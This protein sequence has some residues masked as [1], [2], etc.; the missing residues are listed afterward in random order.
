MFG[1]FKR[2]PAGAKDGER[3]GKEPAAQP[4]AAGPAELIARG[5]RLLDAGRAGEAAECYRQAAALAPDDPAPHVNLGF[6]LMDLGRPAEARQSLERAL[7]LSPANADAH[8]MLG[9]LERA[10]GNIDAAIDH[11][12]QVITAQPDLE[13][14]HGELCQT[15]LQA[16]QAV[17]AREVAEQGLARFPA[18]AGLLTCLGNLAL[19][20][21]KHAEAAERFRQALAADPQAAAAH[22]NLALALRQLGRPEEAVDALKQALA[23]APEFVEAYVELGRLCTDLGR[24]PDALASFQRALAYRP[25]SPATHMELGLVQQKL[26]RLDAAADGL[27][28]ALSLQPDYVEAHINLGNILKDQGRLEEAVRCYGRALALKPD[29]Y[30]AH[31]NLGTIRMWQGEMAAAVDSLRRALALRPDGIEAHNNLLFSMNFL[32]DCTPEAYLAEAR[33]FGAALTARARPY[34][35]W[36]CEGDPPEQRPLRVGLVSGDFRNHPVGYFLETILANVDPARLELTAYATQPAEDALTA[37]I[38]PRFARWRSLAGLDDE[39]AAALIHEDGIHLLVDLSGHTA[40]HRLPVFAWRP[41]PVQLSWL[42]YFAT[43]GVAEIDYLLADPVAI[44]EAHRG[45]FSEEVCYLPDTRLCFTPP[46]VAPPVAPLPAAR[47]GFVT[48]GCFQNLP[49]ITDAVLSAWGAILRRMPDA[50]LRLQ[51]YQLSI[52]AERERLR[53]R[54]TGA[55]IAP[56]RASLHG[57]MSRADYLAAYAE[58]D[59]L[60]DTFP[61]PGGTTTCEALWMGVPT[62]TLEGD[63]MLE[64]QG[65]GMMAC[66][67]LPDWVA[68]STDEYVELALRHAADRDG[69]A[70]LRADLRRKAQASPLFDA[71]RFARNLEEA[72]QGM[73][74]RG[75]RP[76]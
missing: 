26:G 75:A 11:F 50:R 61:F 16:G 66:A 63:R 23:L 60:L 69:L 10:S 28:R 48:F 15:L 62:L 68:R 5:N 12:G 35:H 74:R 43:T 56:E 54:L 67:G 55:G 30:E 71:P 27:R 64:R 7:A 70:R 9:T 73:W 42:G 41:A 1:W 17:R 51:N 76:R 21:R 18:S 29:S 52:E 57:K 32:P 72:L 4:A 34:A 33:A 39:R 53:A 19:T 45:R 2:A 59:L 3:A 38:K 49:K 25:D 37:R 31:N 65:A 20:E 36:R 58:V 22:F 24:Q 47:N 13:T 6:V 14:A 8:F 40:H 46:E 44:P